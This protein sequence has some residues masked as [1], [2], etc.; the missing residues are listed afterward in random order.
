MYVGIVGG[1]PTL[2]PQFKQFVSLLI[3]RK[4][5]LTVF[6][7]GLMPMNTVRFLHSLPLG[8]CNVLLNINQLESYTC[9][10]RQCLKVCMLGLGDRLSLGHTIFEAGRDL[11]FLIRLIKRYRLARIIRI[12]LAHPV[13]GSSNHFLPPVLY[14]KASVH[15]VRLVRSCG[16][17]G[18]S[19]M[20]DCGFTRCAFRRRDAQILQKFGVHLQ[21]KCP[22][23]VDV[24][25]DLTVWRCFATSNRWN[26]KLG[27]FNNLA[28]LQHYFKEKSRRLRL[29]EFSGI[30]PSCRRCPHR[31]SESC[32]SGCLG[33]APA[34]SLSQQKLPP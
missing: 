30:F 9:Q 2:H 21:T 1:E 20:L 16:Q 4:L 32:H 33:H 26:R 22:V 17:N 28:H 31:A 18:I 25:P 5:R 10:Q 6:T 7:N 14:R 29:E 13:W 3:A 8:Q 11:S 12:S 15:I 23:P 24:A 19:L 27:E 34:S